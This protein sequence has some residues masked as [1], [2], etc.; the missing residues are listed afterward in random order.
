MNMDAGQ[1]MMRS[2]RANTRH[3]F[4][5][6]PSIRSRTYLKPHSFHYPNFIATRRSKK[7][8]NQQLILTTTNPKRRP[9]HPPPPLVRAHNNAV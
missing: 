3:F 5:R 8:E 1:C 6:H 9:H 2:R 7:K 4:L